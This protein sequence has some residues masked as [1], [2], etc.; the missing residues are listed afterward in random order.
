MGSQYHYKMLARSKPLQNV[1]FLVQRLPCPQVYHTRTYKADG[2]TSWNGGKDLASSA[3]FTWAFCRALLESW[4]NRERRDVIEIESSQSSLAPSIC[5]AN[6]EPEGSDHE[7]V[8][9]CSQTSQPSL[10][11]STACQANQEPEGSDHEM[12]VISS[13]SDC[14][15]PQWDVPYSDKSFERTKVQSKLMSQLAF[16]WQMTEW[17]NCCAVDGCMIL[18]LVVCCWLTPC[19]SMYKIR[20]V[21]TSKTKKSIHGFTLMTS[22]VLTFEEWLNHYGVSWH[23]KLKPRFFFEKRC[24]RTT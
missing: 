10:E 16:L 4:T 2:S 15:T 7:M 22:E 20:R 12:V 8:V 3:V 19:T 9:A 13:Q 14:G 17:E 5:Q 18:P 6:Q 21:Y 11:P 24:W 23:W 1:T